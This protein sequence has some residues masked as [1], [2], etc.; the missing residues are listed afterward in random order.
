[1][2]KKDK[3][4]IAVELITCP[5]CEGNKVTENN[6]ICPAC[7][8]K[9][10]Y[11]KAK[12]PILGEKIYYWQENISGFS[13]FLRKISFLVP[14]IIQA[15]L[16]LIIFSFILVGL[17]F[18]FDERSLG[19]SFISLGGAIVKEESGA[20]SSETIETFWISSSLD[21]LILVSEQ[22][23][24][25][26][27]FWLGMLGLM[28]LYYYAES[29]D[30][31][32]KEINPSD[33]E[34]RIFFKI[35]SLA[36]EKARHLKESKNDPVNISDYLSSPARRT[37]LMALDTDHSLKQA[38]HPLHLMKVLLE[39]PKTETIFKGIRVTKI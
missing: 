2:P 39:N 8:G 10:V 31:S 32:K 11:L 23:D 37:L 6:S 19:Q 38:P 36:K 7:N 27:M 20:V 18:V 35:P 28:Y 24:K 30:C 5:E 13:P 1:M 21:P 33:K 25:T 9:G 3:N 17:K 14:K 34:F 22:N 29:R 26:L 12:S 4:K 15:V 16:C